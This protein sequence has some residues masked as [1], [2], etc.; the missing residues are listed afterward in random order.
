LGKRLDEDVFPE[1]FTGG[2]A[3]ED[4]LAGAGVAGGARPRVGAGD[5]RADGPGQRD[6]RQ[7]A[8]D[9]GGTVPQRPVRDTFDDRPPPVSRGVCRQHELR[10]FR[11]GVIR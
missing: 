2:L 6:E 9:R 3:V 8:E 11:E 10:S 4:G 5:D 1:G 7:P